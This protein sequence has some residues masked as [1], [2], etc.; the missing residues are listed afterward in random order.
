MNWSDTTIGELVDFFDHKRVPL[1]SSQRE[2]FKGDYRY[3]GAQGIIDYV[4]EYLFDGSYLLVAEDGENLR[5]RNQPI[6]FS[7]SGKFWVN[8]HAHIIKGKSGIADDRFIHSLLNTIPVDAYITGAAQPKLSQANMKA[9]KVNVPTLPTQQKIGHI[10]SAY[11]DLIEN[12]L[13]RIK[14]LEE[15]AQITYEQW[16]VRMKFPGHETTSIDAE[17][18]LPEGWIKTTCF[19]AMDVLSGGTP[20]TTLDEYWN[21]GIKFFTPKDAVGGFYSLETEKSITQLGLKKCNSKLYPKDTL[22]ITA[23]GTVGKLNLA[24][25]SMAMN[26]SCYALQ[27]KEGVTQYFIYCSLSKTIDAFKGA[28]NGGVFDTIVVD[29]F[30]FLPFVMPLPETVIAFTK[31][32]E[33][34]FG[35]VKNL[36]DQNQYLKEARDILL[37]RLMTGLINVDHIELPPTK[38]DS[39]AA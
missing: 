14:L 32:V 8:N 37:P 6:A 7:I 38:K 5:S 3:Y 25:E 2:Q 18:G 13:K 11:D 27:A 10:L 26:Q 36:L 30:K 12:N 31:I 19:K 39:E 9:I 1:S 34:I 22:F 20:K 16:F 33:P 4:K 35:S 28:A 17:T 21:G 29:T 23:R 15:M 24:S